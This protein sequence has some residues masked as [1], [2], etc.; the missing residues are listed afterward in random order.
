MVTFKQIANFSI[1]WK[2]KGKSMKILENNSPCVC[3]L[4]K[5]RN[6]GV[7]CS[8]G[9]PNPNRVAAYEF[10]VFQKIHPED[11][12]MCTCRLSLTSQGGV[13]TAV[14]VRCERDRDA[15]SSLRLAVRGPR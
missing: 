15:S 11:Q 6:T 8:T 12:Q 5:S 10:V 13:L 7:P 4:A 2:F 9:A 3:Y 14:V 1:Q